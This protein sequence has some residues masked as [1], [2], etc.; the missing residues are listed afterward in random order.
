ML[1][2]LN[3]II[4]NNKTIDRIICNNTIVYQR[5]W[6]LLFDGLLTSAG[7]KLDIYPFYKIVINNAFFVKTPTTK[8]NTI[9][10]AGH[11]ILALQD[12]HFCFFRALEKV[13]LSKFTVKIRR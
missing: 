9:F 5:S 6:D 8:N 3:N 11:K 7:K 12:S 13:F 10:L 2:D 1:K 4:I